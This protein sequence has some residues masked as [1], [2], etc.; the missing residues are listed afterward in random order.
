MVMNYY[1]RID[2]NTVQFDFLL[3]RDDK[4][5]YDDEIVA[6]GGKIYR[7]LP[8]YPQNYFLYKKAIK[9]F[10]DEHPEYHIIHSNMTETGLFV[11]QEAK[12]RGIP[13]RIVHAHTAVTNR[14]LSMKTL[15]LKVYKTAIKKYLTHMFACGKAAAQYVFGTTQNVIY[16][17]NA[18]DTAIFKYNENTEA[19]VRREF[20]IEGNFVIGHVGRFSEPKNHTF[21]IDIFNEVYKRNPNAVLVL[22][23]GFETE[24]EAISRI[25]QKVHILGLDNVVFFA[26]QRDDV[27]RIMQAFDVFI[28]PSLWEGFPVV[29]VE[30]Q[31]LGI[32]CLISDK[33]SDECLLTDC[34][35]VVPLD[36]G[37]T[38][39][40]SAIIESNESNKGLSACNHIIACG[41]DIEENARWLQQ[42]YLDILASNASLVNN[43]KLQ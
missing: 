14:P 41:Y 21:I 36:A 7:I 10:F 32:R 5:A 15:V 30:A 39:W 18:I 37:A 3:H 12:K 11:F 13:I 8:P 2:R 4:G 40:A 35:K 19:A 1:R 27:H 9:K 26:G 17:P 43:T 23:G 25:K 20:N 6:L 24:T 38:G 16:L 42:L 31:S 29:M 28:L 34:S 33:V 22:V